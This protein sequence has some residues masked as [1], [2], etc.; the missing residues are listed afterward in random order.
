MYSAHSEEQREIND[1]YNDGD[2]QP[3]H[4]ETVVKDAFVCV[5]DE[6]EDVGDQKDGEKVPEIPGV[7]LENQQPII[8]GNQ[9]QYVPDKKS[10][11]CKTVDGGLNAFITHDR[12][13]SRIGR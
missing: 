11:C 1:E 12:V 13:P 6:Y 10:Y 9:H 2:G 3:S 4:L 7:L 8:K 5:C